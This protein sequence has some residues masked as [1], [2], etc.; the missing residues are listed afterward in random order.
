MQISAALTK[1]EQPEEEPISGAYAAQ[2]DFTYVVK[3][4]SK[5]GY[6]FLLA[7]NALAD[8]KSCGLKPDY[9]R[10]RMAFQLSVEDSRSLFGNKGASTL[11][12][13]ICQFDD[14]LERYSFRPYLHPGISWEG[15][16]V[17]ET[18][19]VQNPFGEGED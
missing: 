3:Q 7:L 1:P 19:K 12:E 15:W 4:G 18:G 11:P 14:S 9:F 13:H 17:D 2:G 16:S 8:L 10:Y 5:L 6:H